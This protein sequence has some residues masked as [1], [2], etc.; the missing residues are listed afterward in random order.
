MNFAYLKHTDG[1][2]ALYAACREAE[3]FALVRPSISAASARKAMEFV[4]RR[5]YA[6]VEPYPAYGVTVYDMTRDPLFQDRLAGSSMPGRIEAIRRIGNIAVHQG[7]LTAEDS[8]KALEQL[9]FLV[10]EFAV[11]MG[12]IREC[13]AFVKPVPNR[14]GRVLRRI[15]PDNF[16]LNI[17]PYLHADGHGEWAA[18]L[19]RCRK[20]HIAEL[21]HLP[22]ELNCDAFMEFLRPFER[23]VKEEKDSI[24]DALP[25]SAAT[26]SEWKARREQLPEAAVRRIE[27]FVEACL[28]D[29]PRP[30]AKKW[31]QYNQA[32]GDRAAAFL[33]L[34]H[35][36]YVLASMREAYIKPDVADVVEEDAYIPL[37]DALRQLLRHYVAENPRKRELLTR[38]SW[39]REYLGLPVQAIR[40]SPPAGEMRAQYS[41]ESV[42]LG[43][44]KY[45][46]YLNWERASVMRLRQLTGEMGERLVTADRLADW[47]FAVPGSPAAEQAKQRAARRR[48]MEEMEAARRAK[49]EAERPC[50]E[51]RAKPDPRRVV[52]EDEARPSMIRM[53]LDDE[54]D[55]KDWLPRLTCAQWCRE[56]LG[57]ENPVLISE[58]EPQVL[59]RRQRN[60]GETAHIYSAVMCEC[61]GTR[62]FIKRMT[63]REFEKLSQAVHATQAPAGET[64]CERREL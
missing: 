63:T 48:A 44:K 6:E 18:I 59:L 45:W 38:Q 33:Q 26:Q 40:C 62:Y 64:A 31:T 47:G 32:L 54:L 36:E 46:V 58:E 52:S 12:I 13:P 10:G 43:N 23:S 53:F 51:A 30:G 24:L 22:P 39:C 28:Y 55:L 50:V 60:R 1:F 57:V 37:E 2:E 42:H 25:L 35:P 19:T 20:T 34:V 16:S 4:V 11:G 61:G 14:I 56:V 29:H 49:E 27:L 3:E 41:C 8:M 21:L 15:H 7:D 5:L 17:L 9:H